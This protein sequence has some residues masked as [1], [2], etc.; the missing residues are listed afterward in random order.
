MR[1]D[2]DLI[3]E[4]LLKLEALPM[5]TGSVVHMM[6]DDD[7]IRVD[8]FDAGAIE[9]HAKL[10]VEAGLID[11]GTSRVMQGITFRSLTWAGHDFLDAIR[12]PEI[13][14]KTKK[15]AA[16]AGGFTMDLLRDLATGFIKKQVEELTG[17]KIG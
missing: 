7:E 17:V 1:R 11:S 5:T 15:G 16:A 12:D 9:Y 10:L 6:P 2:M 8:G 13:W 3:R 4:L 14:A